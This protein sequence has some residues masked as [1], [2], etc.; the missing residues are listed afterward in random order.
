MTPIPET[1]F[2]VD[3]QAQRCQLTTRFGRRRSRSAGRYAEA[4]KARVLIRPKEGILDP[5]GKAVEGALPALGFEQI[6]HVRV[7]RMVELEA[8]SDEQL[9]ELCEKLLANPLIEDYEIQTLD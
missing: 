8:G 3:W 1:P 6:S 5:Q 4:V 2:N 7:G 9:A